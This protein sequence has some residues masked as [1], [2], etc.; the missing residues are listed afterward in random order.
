MYKPPIEIFTD[1]L[2]F[3]YDNNIVEAVQRYDINVDKDELLKALRYDRQQYEKGFADGKVA[4][5]QEIVRCKDCEWWTKQEDSAQGRCTLLGIYP[6][7][8][9]YCGNGRRSEDEMVN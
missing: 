7:G 9:W 4:A 1:E 6:T 2:K 8:A 3:Y 5:T